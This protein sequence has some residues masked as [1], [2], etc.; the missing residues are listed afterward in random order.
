M[1]VIY[2]TPADLS[3]W[4]DLVE[5]VSWNFPGLETPEKLAEHRNTVLRFMEDHRAVCVKEQG[6]VIGVLLFSKKHNMICCLAV[7]PEHRRRGIAS[8]LLTEALSRLDRSRDITVTTFREEDD[9]GNAPRA[10]YKHFG[11]LAGTLFLEHDYPVQEFILIANHSQ[12]T[13]VEYGKEIE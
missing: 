10:L 11:F 8:L 12:N 6:D 7:A 4:M 2:G 1:N 5:R 9:K 13:G 3:S